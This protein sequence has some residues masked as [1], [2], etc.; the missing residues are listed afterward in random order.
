MSSVDEIL[1]QSG[2]LPYPPI[3]GSIEHQSQRDCSSPLLWPSVAALLLAA[4]PTS[5]LFYLIY[6][7][8]RLVTRYLSDRFEYLF[9]HRSDLRFSLVYK[10]E[11]GPEVVSDISYTIG[12]SGNSSELTFLDASLDNIRIE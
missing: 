4:L 10:M 7:F 8:R 6:I 11:C 12:D 2:V 1:S 3:L 9:T 5:F